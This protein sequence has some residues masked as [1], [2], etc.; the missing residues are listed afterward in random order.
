MDN[1]K[2][3]SSRDEVSNLASQTVVGAKTKRKSTTKRQ[4]AL[5]LPIWEFINTNRYLR[6]IL[7]KFLEDYKADQDTKAS[8]PPPKHCC[9]FCLPKCC[10]YT[11]V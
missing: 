3:E 4:A 10:L 5:P 7:L 8:L 9:N 1:T 6:K 2:V 11:L